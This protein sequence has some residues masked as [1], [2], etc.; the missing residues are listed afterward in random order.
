MKGDTIG[1]IGG[2]SVEDS[3][4]LAHRDR[5]KIG[6]TR[7]LVVERREKAGEAPVTKNIDVTYA[8]LP[9]R[10]MLLRYGR[11]LMGFCF[12]GCAL[13]ACLKIPAGSA[14]LLALFGIC[15][16]ATFMGGPYI[17]SYFLRMLLGSIQILLVLLG[18]AFLRSEEHTS[19]LQSPCNL[20]CR[21]LLEN[22]EQ[23]EILPLALRNRG[24][25]MDRRASC[26][27]LPVKK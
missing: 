20:V 19:E 1:S 16:G 17:A 24:G 13:I 26:N 5:P 11:V 14:T 4:A 9:D 2:I 12:L 3:S 27:W 8:G 21:L 25:K 18:F 7:T 15:F 22:I 23:I 10:D 6:E